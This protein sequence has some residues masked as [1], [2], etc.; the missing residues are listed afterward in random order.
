MDDIE[1]SLGKFRLEIFLVYIN[2]DGGIEGGLEAKIGQSYSPQRMNSLVGAQ[3]GQM[4]QHSERPRE[5]MTK[6]R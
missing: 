4:I 6:T 5:M 3:N 1:I 2:V